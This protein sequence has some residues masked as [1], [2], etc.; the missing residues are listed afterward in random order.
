MKTLYISDLDGT[1]LRNDE[2]TSEYTNQTLNS[3]VE[4]GMLFSYAT[5]RSYTT[6]QKVTKGLHAQIPVIVY[7]GAFII[8][9]ATGEI[10]LS[11]YFDPDVKG[12][13]DDLTK[14]NIYPIVYSYIDS[15]EKFSFWEEKCTSGMTAFLNTRKGDKRT[16]PVHT[17]SQLYE[18]NIFYISCIDEKAKLQPFHEKY[19]N[20]YHCV[21]HQ[22]LY[23]KEQWLEIM[24]LTVTKANA[25]KQLKEYF[26]CDKLIVFGDGIN[27]VDMFELADECY[28]VENAVAKLKDISTQIIGGNDEDGVAKWLNEHY[29]RN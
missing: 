29:A 28:A 12:L 21:F 1:L 9:N 23:T 14:H 18:G 19:Q 17:V 4:Q 24:P 6:S 26:Q 7:N 15:V 11:N 5:A 10:L 22:E 27:D 20:Q 25:I 3:L 2:R 16:N 8:D 13:L